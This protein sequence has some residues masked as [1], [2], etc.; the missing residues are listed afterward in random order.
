MLVKT[1]LIT[2]KGQL[3]LLDKFKKENQ[4]VNMIYVESIEDFEKK[5]KYKNQDK[6]LEDYCE[7]LH[8]YMQ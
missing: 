1:T 6:L 5:G 2:G 8:G 3:F 4:E 7:Y